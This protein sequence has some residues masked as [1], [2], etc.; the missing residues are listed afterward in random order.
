[1]KMKKIIIIPALLFASQCFAQSNTPNPYASIGKEAKILTLSDGR[2]TEIFE[3]DTL[4]RIGSVMFNT[5]TNKIAYF[6]D[7]N[8]TSFQ[9]AISQ[10]TEAS[11]WVSTDPKASKFPE[12]SPYCF[13]GNNPIYYVDPDGQVIRPASDYS[14][15][16]IGEAIFQVFKSKDIALQLF[17]FNVEKFQEGKDSY[18]LITSKNNYTSFNQFKKALKAIGK[19][20]GV[21]YSKEDLQDAYNAYNKINEKAVHE[22]LVTNSEQKKDEGNYEQ[23]TGDEGTTNLKVKSADLLKTVINFKN[24]EEQNKSTN[25][26]GT[27]Y[28]A[29]KISEQK[30]DYLKTETN[31]TGTKTYNSGNTLINDNGDKKQGAEQ[32]KEVITTE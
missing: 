23:N 19:K 13:A 11:R 20:E 29:S 30:S 4:Q 16:V 26:D 5:V 25:T 8:D 31:G 18:G 3:E 9:I 22:I 21:K 2:Y 28:D 15:G 1:M 10:P 14:Q 17:D 7:E 32:V 6:I 27:S 24:I 12:M